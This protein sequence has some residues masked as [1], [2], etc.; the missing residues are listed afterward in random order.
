VRALLPALLAGAA[1]AVATLPSAATRRVRRLAAGAGAGAG[2]GAPPSRAAP[3]PALLAGV[4]AVTL[5]P[6]AGA[7]CLGAAYAARYALRRRAAAASVREVAAAL[8]DACRA[9]AAELRAGAPPGTALTRAAAD[10]PL[11]LAAHLRRI[12]ATTQLGPPPPPEAWA[13]LP[14]AERLRAVGALWTVAAHAGNGL[15]D[16]LDRLADSLAAEQRQRAEVAAQLAGPTASA[17][18]LAA[19]PA[20]GVGL[21]AALGAR[22]LRFLLGTPAGFGCLVL[23]AALDAAG[24]WWVRRLTVRAA[25]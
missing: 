14:G 2:A 13:A 4:A 9:A 23:G 15:A 17:V 24:L 20:C 16:G 10:A 19:L 3:F 22:P 25:A 7:A 18:V 6:A 12:A 8:P 1:Y 11:P 5:G 21:A